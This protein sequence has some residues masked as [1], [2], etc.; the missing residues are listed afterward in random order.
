MLEAIV[1]PQS[2]SNADSST[3]RKH[4]SH[5]RPMSQSSLIL[6]DSDIHT[7]FFI[8]DSVNKGMQNEGCH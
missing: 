1:M 6:P 2:H 4:N 7:E 5:R 8:S 3:K